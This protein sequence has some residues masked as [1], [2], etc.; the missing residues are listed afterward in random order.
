MFL[1]MVKK[2]IVEEKRKKL[3]YHRSSLLAEQRDLS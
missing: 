2:N 1:S 3:R